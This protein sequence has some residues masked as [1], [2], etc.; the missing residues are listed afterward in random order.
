MII[1]GINGDSAHAPERGSHDSG[2]CLLENGRVLAASNE[3]RFSRIK[4]DVQYPFRAIEHALEYVGPRSVSSAA[5]SWLSPLQQKPMLDRLFRHLKRV[6]N[7]SPE[8]KRFYWK[9]QSARWARLLRIRRRTLPEKIAH[10]PIEICEHH[11]A[12]AASAY[13]CAPFGDARMLVLTLDGQGDFAAGSAWIG[14]KGTLTH[15][16]HYDA[17]NSI[18]HIYAAFTGHLGFTP[19]RHE[20]KIVGLAAHGDP[21]TLCERLLAKTRLGDWHNMLDADLVL[22]V[23]RPNSDEGKAAMA[24]LCDGLSREAIAAGIQTWAEQVATAMVRDLCRRHDCS[25]L[26]LAGGVFANVKLN[27][28]ILELDEVENLYIHPN[29]GDGGLAVGAALVAYAAANNGMTPQFL[30]TC[31]LGPD[32][33]DEAADAALADAG[34]KGEVPADMA[35]RAAELLASGKVVARAAG[36]MEYGPRAL[37]NRTLFASCSDPSINKWLN[38]RLQRTEFMPFAPIIMEEYAAEYFPA[39]K[40]E[41]VAARFMTITYDA[42]EIAK[43]NIPAAIHVDGTA[44]PQVLR[45]AD[46]PEVY[47]ML[48]AFHAKTGVPALINTS[49]NMHEE[50]IV[51][52]AA[53]AVRAFT[54]GNID[55]LIVG[56]RLTLGESA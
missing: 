15:I 41:H 53:D 33:S 13:Y 47:A 20:G 40:P 5:L 37:G 23:L 24:R 28:R 50:P 19:N 6:A 16:E 52:N 14:E 10:C 25:L 54:L 55:A 44:R 29:M 3:E 21:T 32:I 39:W 27:Q 45:E 11:H 46:N 35:A 2:A 43:K 1:I 48:K 51:C 42:S 49:F 31:Y 8:L 30:D 22:L 56:N 18:G 17:L 26:A 12:H 34:I 9:Q 38:D 7:D 4:Q 36:R